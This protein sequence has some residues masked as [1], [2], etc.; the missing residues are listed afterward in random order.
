MVHGINTLAKVNDLAVINAKIKDFGM[1]V[2]FHQLPPGS[3][4]GI[5]HSVLS[6]CKT[7]RLFRYTAIDGRMKRYGESDRGEFVYVVV[8]DCWVSEIGKGQ[9]SGKDRGFDGWADDH[10]TV[11]C[12]V[13]F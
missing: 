8:D 10:C 12:P 3:L 1:D 11:I 7:K 5:L 2:V 9:Y 4:H 6:P 13:V